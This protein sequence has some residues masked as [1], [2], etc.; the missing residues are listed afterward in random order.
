MPQFDLRDHCR[1]IR[2]ELLAAFGEVLDAG[3]FILGPNV[4]AFEEE[5]AAYLGVA[6]TVAVNSGTDALILALRGLGVGA[7]DEVVTSAFTFVSPAEAASL[8]GARPVFVDIEA[9]GFNLDPGRLEAALSPRTRAIVVVHLFGQAAD[10]EPVLE[11]ARLHGIAVVED[12]CQA[13]GADYRGRKV[14]AWGSAGC[15]SFFPTKNLGALGDG[16]LL[17]TSDPA[18][19]SRVRALRVHG[20]GPKYHHR[21]TGYNSRLDELQA[22]VLRVKLKHLEGWIARRIEIAKGYDERLRAAGLTEW[23]ILPAHRTYGRHVFH[24]YALR[25]LSGVRDALREHLAKKGIGTAVYYPVPLHLQE[26]YRGLGY[27]LGDLP[28][29]ERAAAEVLCLPMF[30]E[31][32]PEQQDRVVEEIAG[33]FKTRREG[34]R[35]SGSCYLQQP[36]EARGQSALPRGPLGA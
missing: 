25:V 5:M 14:A 32:R 9:D 20:S 18:L 29:A 7:G 28:R 30:P 13:I 4:S 27:R 16:G 35:H 34:S 15:L 1:A 10:L 17:S 33:F 36:R 22:A 11:M 6:H 2:S 23:L 12:A 31:L 19:A 21:M 8:L 3:Q 26:V 24:Q